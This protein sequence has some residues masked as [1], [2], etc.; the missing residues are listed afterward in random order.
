MK[1]VEKEKSLRNKTRKW[2]NSSN[3]SDFKTEKM[4]HKKNILISVD[5]L[6]NIKQYN[7][8]YWFKFTSNY[9]WNKIY[10][11]IDFEKIGFMLIG[12]KEQKY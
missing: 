2:E 6:N 4:Q 11:T 9:I 10:Y 5:F 12:E 3:M 1:E 8:W 7:I